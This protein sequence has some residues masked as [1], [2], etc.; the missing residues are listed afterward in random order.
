MKFLRVIRFDGS[1]EHVF[2]TAAQ[3]DEWVVSG[4][5][6]FADLAPQ[7]LEGKTRQAFANG[8]LG[9]RSLGRSTFA[10]VAEMT[11]A[12]HEELVAA[13]A[14]HFLA[15]YGAPGREEATRAAREEAGFVA[16]LC[17]EKPVNAVFTVRRIM[18]EGEIREEFREISPPRERPHTRVWDVVD[19][20]A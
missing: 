3:P 1:D 10:A 12:E 13:L 18:D 4:A 11:G 14:D 7:Q 8:F 20:D 16:D 6:A 2:E 17:A 9:I 19:D 5:F 15:C